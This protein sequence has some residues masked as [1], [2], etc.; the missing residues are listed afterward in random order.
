[1]GLAKGESLVVLGPSGCGKSTL[2]NIL[3]GFQKPDQGRVQIDGRTLEGPGGERGVVCQDDARMPWLNALD[4]V[5]LGLRIR[6]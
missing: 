5:A 1:L 2:L 6:G 4:N 3:A